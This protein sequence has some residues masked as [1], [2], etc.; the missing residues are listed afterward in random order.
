MNNPIIQHELLGTLRTRK[1]VIVQ[2]TV[3]MSLASLVILR[4]PT[5]GRI[6]RSFSESQQV[7]QLFGYGLLACVMLLAP[8]FP[9]T[10]IVRE[11]RSGTLGL[12][13]NSPLRPTAI[14]FGKLIGTLGFLG[15]L[16][17]LSLPAAMACYSM[18]GII[19]ARFA[20]CTSFSA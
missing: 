12:L 1:A 10:T 20:M 15:L 14:Y 9:A 19:P 18:D 7:M 2:L 4:W 3:A 6:D 8:I 17:V 5:D 16:L 11:R 13:L